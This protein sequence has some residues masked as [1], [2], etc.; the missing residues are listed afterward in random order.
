MIEWKRL[1]ANTPYSAANNKTQDDAVVGMQDTIY[2]TGPGFGGYEARVK[3]YNSA[4]SVVAEIPVCGY[5]GQLS[6]PASGHDFP[7]DANRR[8][9][10]RYAACHV[11]DQL[12]STLASFPRGIG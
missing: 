5:G 11:L 10:D 8:G 4:G 3:I 6:A 2:V 9:H 7:I 1:Y 12:V